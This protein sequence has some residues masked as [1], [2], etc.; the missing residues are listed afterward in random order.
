MGSGA[1][2]R[3]GN[4]SI[5]GSDAA[6]SPRC[7]ALLLVSPELHHC[8]PCPQ[9]SVHVSQLGALQVTIDIRRHVPVT[10]DLLAGNYAQWR[11]HFDTIIGMFG[12]RDHVDADAVQRPDDPEWVMAD[13]AILHWL[14]TTVAPDLLDAVMQNEDTAFTVWAA[15]D[16]IFRDNQLAPAVYVD[17]E[18]HAVVQGDMTIMQYCTK[19]KSYTDELRD[20]GQPV[21]D[22]QQL[23]HLLRGLGRQY[24]GAIPHLTARTPL[25][26]FLQ[27]RSFLLLEELRAE[28]SARQQGAHTLVAGHGVGVP[29]LPPTPTPT[30]SPP[31]SDTGASRG[32]GRQRRRGRGGGGGPPSAPPGVPR[33]GSLPAPAPGSNSWTGLM[34]AWPMPWRAPGTGV[35]GPRPGTPHQQAMFAA[36][37]DPAPGAYNYGYGYAPPPPGYAAPPPYGAPGAPVAPYQPLDMASL[38]AALHSA[39]AGPSSSGG[40]SDWYMD[41][42]A[43]SHMTNSPGNLHTIYP[44]SS[45]S[46]IIVG[47]GEHLPI[48]HT[49]V[50]SFIAGTSPLQLRNVQVAPSLI[51]NLMSVRQLCRDNPVTVEFDL[52]GFTIK[53]LRTRAAILRCDSPGDLYPVAASSPAHSP[54]AGVAAVDLLHQRLGHPGSASVQH[55]ASQ[56]QFSFSKSALHTDNRREFDNASS[57]EF[58]ARHGAVLR[59][60]CPYTSQ[61]NGSPSPCCP[62]YAIRCA[63]HCRCARITAFNWGHRIFRG[64]LTS[65]GLARALGALER[66]RPISITRLCSI[67]R[68]AL[69]CVQF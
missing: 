27:A 52:L 19:L 67:V 30:P 40:S 60:S 68:F 29:P 16:A 63:R 31:T 46:H 56:L 36:P 34:Q 32:R 65:V 64:R 39:T 50:G 17:A 47:S 22:T 21:D 14:N 8:H 25:P 12:L 41:S 51:K 20:L 33:P 44:S 61:Q 38:Q 11:R 45:H 6:L 53:D 66:D 15:I 54:F 2:T 35:L 13:H 69:G 58:F 5:G 7:F 48:T 49:G 26:S 28:Q 62:S 9:S 59:L 18:Y 10:L 42:G 43:A 23:F 24:H 1:A 37:H 57:R 4:D 55:V 3:I